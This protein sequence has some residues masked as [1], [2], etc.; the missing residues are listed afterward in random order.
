MDQL[1]TPL[2]RLLRKPGPGVTAALAASVLV[3][4]GA[5]AL[6]ARRPAP[7]LASP[8]QTLAVL[9]LAGGGANGDS[10]W[11]GPAL[12]QVVGAGLHAAGGPRLVPLEDVARMQ[13]ELSLPTTTALSAA[14]RRRV[15]ED[16]H[17][18]YVVSGETVPVGG[19]TWR[20]ALRLTD[21]ATGRT[22]AAAEESGDEGALAALA[23]RASARLRPGL[24]ARAL[25]PHDDEAARAALP[26][27][28]DALRAYGRGLFAMQ[29]GENV[30]AARWFGEAA[31]LE[32]QH[33][34]SHLMLAIA[35]KLTGDVR[36]GEQAA[37]QASAL[38][39]G[40]EREE[41]LSIEALYRELHHE[42]DRAIALYQALL[43]FY[44]NRVDWALQLALVQAQARRPD[45]CKATLDELRRLP[46]PD[47]D[48]PSIDVAEAWCLEASSDYRRMRELAARA[49]T[50]AQKRG[51]RLLAARAQMLESRALYRL[52]D[53][54]GALQRLVAAQSVFHVLGDSGMEARAILAQGDIWN[55]RRKYPDARECFEKALVTVR[56]Q[57]DVATEL[58]VLNNLAVGAE[59]ARART[60]YQEV[61]TLARSNG[62]PV[63]VI[64]ATSNLAMLDANADDVANAT[65]GYDEALRLA[66][67]VGIRQLEGV[68]LTNLCGLLQRSGDAVGALDAC[69]Q[70]DATVAKT[71]SRMDA[72]ECEMNE[73]PVLVENH[74]EAEAEATARRAAAEAHSLGVTAVEV[75]ALTE[76]ATVLV[77]ERR[78]R[79]AGEAL[80]TARARLAE[81]SEAEAAVYVT[82]AEAR[83][84]GAL[85]RTPAAR[86]AAAQT[87][88]Q[89]AALARAG[90]YVTNDRDA[91]L[92]HYQLLYAA[93][94][95][96]RVK[97]Q[98]AAL[99]AESRHAGDL[100]VARP[101]AALL[102]RH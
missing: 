62:D 9:P 89:A 61:M 81:S 36:R 75:I 26:S 92:L 40:L 43:S 35:R 2:R 88:A 97:A 32:P 37:A 15:R 14:A 17:A 10:A 51:A 84:Q 67:Q 45:G 49:Q 66:R 44:P 19:K 33:A 91:R 80:A 39:K 4:G 76:L 48:D 34:Y 50:Q 38:S 71:N 27:R 82:L 79:E 22:L 99:E 31:T 25:A 7:V 93:G 59:P 78:L 47:P 70:A 73:F 57:G 96:A 23:M 8:L 74:R 12:A 72:V 100:Y 58:Q 77:D 68:A 69:R 64:L 6:S 18:D 102:R 63:G 13:R 20:V 54:D 16:L 42:Y 46:P 29:L 60:L 24:G 56:A 90:G 87:A 1:L 86:V 55:A 53:P 21:L 52:G 98:L 30:Q 28:P 101:A 83:L 94:Q 85:A 65:R 41:Q 95:G 5:I 11:L 3:A